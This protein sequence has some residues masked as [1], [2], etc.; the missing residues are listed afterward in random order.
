MPSCAIP[1][2]NWNSLGALLDTSVLIGG[3]NFSP[4]AKLGI[5]VVCVWVL[6]L[7]LLKATDDEKRARRAE[8]LGL[9]EARFPDPIP[10]DDQVARVWGQLQAAV[11]SRGVNP[12]KRLADLAIAATARVHQIPLLTNNLKDFT[13]IDDLVDVRAP[14]PDLPA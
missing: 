2:P 9:I 11:A 13:M 3:A 10:L 4:S 8:R 5:S 12:R 1:G 6:H 7:G 14:G